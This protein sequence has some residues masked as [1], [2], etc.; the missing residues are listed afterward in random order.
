MP[1]SHFL[2][3]FHSSYSWRLWKW[4]WL[5]LAS[6]WLSMEENFPIADDVYFYEYL[7]IHVSHKSSDLLLSFQGK[8]FPKEVSSPS[9]NYA[10][11]GAIYSAVKLGNVVLLLTFR[12]IVKHQIACQG[13]N[14][15]MQ[16]LTGLT[17]FHCP[18]SYPSPPNS[19]GTG[20]HWP[21]MK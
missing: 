3:G 1:G 15:L 13:K 12:K 19:Q 4:L 20:S 18:P 14:D 16:K 2:A 8:F 10:L 7:K 11:W 9:Y 6:A 17:V 21:P 5:P